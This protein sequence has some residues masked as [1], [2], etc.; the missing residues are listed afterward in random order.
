MKII[1]SIITLK[2]LIAYLLLFH[3]DTINVSKSDAGNIFYY[4]SIFIIVYYWIFFDIYRKF[5]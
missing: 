1:Q 4:N 2:S 5:N 3:D